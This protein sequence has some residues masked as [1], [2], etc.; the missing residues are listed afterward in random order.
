[1]SNPN[2]NEVIYSHIK[3]LNILYVED[4]KVTRLLFESIVSKLVNKIIYANDGEEGYQ[5]F[6]DNEVDL[7]ITDYAMPKSNGLDMVEKI[8]E[9]DTEVPIILVSA[10][11]DLEVF[12]RALNLDIS[13]FIRKPINQNELLLSIE[14]MAK[15]FVANKYLQRQ[16]NEQLREL[17]EKDKYKTYQ[18]DLAFEKELNILRNDFYYQMTDYNHNVTLIDFLY[19]PLDVMSGDAYS[20]RRIDEDTILYIV[21]DGMGKGLSAS[22]TAMIFISFANHLIDK[23]LFLDDFS[24][25]IL[26]SET[27]EYIKPILL[28]EESLSLDYV[29]V[30]NK[31]EQLY[32]SK[33]AMPPLLMQNSGLVKIKSNNPPMSKYSQTFNIDKYDISGVTKFIMYSDGIVENETKFNNRPYSEFIEQDF[34]ES[35]T[36]EDMK[37]KFMEKID[38][39][40]DDV[41]LIF[42]NRITQ[43]S[44]NI[45]HKKFKSTLANIDIANEWYEALWNNLCT[46]TKTLYQAGMVFTE[47]YMNAHEHGNL[48]I[49]ANYKNYLMENDIY[50]ETLEKKEK[51]VDKYVDIKIDKIKHGSVYYIITK[52]TD[53]GNGFDTQIL[54][55]IFRNSQKFHGRGVFVSRKN[56]FGIYYTSKGNSVLYLNKIEESSL[57]KEA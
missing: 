20:A 41:T 3:S 28:D 13:A 11:E 33:F 45:A 1:M 46:D 55:K 19:H 16:K 43:N 37:N 53:E 9:K 12:I 7:I 51:E 56:S 57:I 14:K 54:S 23:M 38:K 29:L 39:Q 48:A 32:Y 2:D 18:E 4:T 47:L 5:K 22:L 35:F 50:F 52:I 31:D 42:M 25:S 34:I 40:E 27:M 30:N 15:V 36:R 8:R 17:Q 26:I 6:L 49:D 21:V 44:K 10:I 24:L